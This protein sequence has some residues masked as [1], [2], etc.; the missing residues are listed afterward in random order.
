MN[1]FDLTTPRFAQPE[2]LAVTGLA[3]GVLQSWLSRGHITLSE[4]NPGTGRSR[5]YAPLDVVKLTIIAHL[6]RFSIPITY[7]SKLAN[8][9]VNRLEEESAISWELFCSPPGDIKRSVTSEF[10]PTEEMRLGLGIGDLH[11]MRVST[12]TEGNLV[13]NRRENTDLPKGDR[14]E[15]MA[16]LAQIHGFAPGPGNPINPEKRARYARQGI[17]AEPVLIVPV[18]EIANGALLQLDAID[19]GEFTGSM[20]TETELANRRARAQASLTRA[21]RRLDEI[22]STIAAKDEQSKA[23]EASPADER[24]QADES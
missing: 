20:K 22:D 1:E 6:S 16:R 3:S 21:Q 15:V 11:N 4:Q 17:H 14:A 12:F 24:G 8:Y 19:R 5:L 10:G 13:L 7:S 2:V 18:G 23:D 9:V